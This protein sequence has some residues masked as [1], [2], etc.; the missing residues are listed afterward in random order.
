MIAVMALEAARLPI[1]SSRQSALTIG[2]IQFAAAIR[3]E[4]TPDVQCAA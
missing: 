4:R 2:V 3:L 1:L